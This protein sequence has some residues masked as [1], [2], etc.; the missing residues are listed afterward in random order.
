MLAAEPV[1][2]HLFADQTGS[3]MKKQIAAVVIGLGLVGT[4]AACSSQSDSEPTKTSTPSASST[5]QATHNECDKDGFLDI[6]GGDQKAFGD[7]HITSIVDDDRTVTIGS[8]DELYFEGKGNTVTAES[9]KKVDFLS[10]SGNKLVYKGA[11]PEVLNQGDNVVE[12]AK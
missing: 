9:V 2:H 5:F 10:T 7:C 8:S 12:A 1:A 6:A 11:A 4:L 3:I